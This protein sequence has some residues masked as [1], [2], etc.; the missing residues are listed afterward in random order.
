MAFFILIA[1]I[2]VAHEAFMFLDAREEANACTCKVTG[3]D[4]GPGF[5]IRVNCGRHESK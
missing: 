3:Q 4:R 5:T 1:I 2:L